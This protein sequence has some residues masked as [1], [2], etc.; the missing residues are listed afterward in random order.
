MELEGL[1]DVLATPAGTSAVALIQAYDQA[2]QYSP[3]AGNKDKIQNTW[4]AVSIIAG[5][6]LQ[7]VSD[8]MSNYY[9]YGV[10]D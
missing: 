8:G 1:L 6:S 10:R 2:N 3:V 7:I 5:G 9:I 4:S